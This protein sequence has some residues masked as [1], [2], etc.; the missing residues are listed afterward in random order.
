MANAAAA[1]IR[2]ETSGDVAVYRLDLASLKS[3][4]ACAKEINAK[5]SNVDVLINNAGVMMCPL[6]RTEDGFEMQIGT[7]H[8]GH[9]LFTN[10]LLDKIKASAAKSKS[11][12]GGAGARIVTVSSRAHERGR[13]DLDDLNWE[14]R[15]YNRMHAYEQSK[16]AN[17]LFTR[18]LAKRLE[19]TGVSCYS[20]H[21]G[22]VRTELGRHIEDVVGPLKHLLW[23]AI[24]F[25]T[26]N[27]RE[28]AQTSIYCA[29]DE[30][31][32]RETGLYYS[33]CRVKLEM[34]QARDDEMAKKLWEA[35]VKA[36]GL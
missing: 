10:L 17:V 36:T 30:R 5:E 8:F 6:Q 29:V 18:E 14:T 15:P 9:F 2:K 21:P 12:D 27:C 24:F 26:K 23:G 34:P 33:D 11:E 22:V 1:D 35:S 13:V 20:L 28:G 4:R 3:V 16:L 32:G 25:F 31:A 7:N 19:G